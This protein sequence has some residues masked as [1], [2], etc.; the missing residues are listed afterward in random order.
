MARWLRRREWLFRVVLDLVK[1]IGGTKQGYGY[2]LLVQDV[3]SD[4]A[5]QRMVQFVRTATGQRNWSLPSSTEP[6]RRGLQDYVNRIP[7]TS[8]SRP[9]LA[10][11]A[12]VIASRLAGLPKEKIAAALPALT[13]TWVS[14]AFEARLLTHRGFDP[15]GILLRHRLTGL[16]S[17]EVYLA[18]CFA[19]AAGVLKTLLAGTTKSPVLS[20]R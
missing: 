8:F 2:A 1:A 19:Q 4:T 15:I 3:K 12:Y 6:V 13:E 17:R 14:S 11:V 18:G 10:I 5:G 20:I 7:G 16:E 9:L